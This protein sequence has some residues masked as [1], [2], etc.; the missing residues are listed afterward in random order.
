MNNKMK[1]TLDHI[2]PSCIS[3][4]MTVFHIFKNV[5]VNSVLNLKTREQAVGFPR[6]DIVLG[7][8]ENCGF[9][10]NVAF[11]SALLEYSAEY[12]STQS[13]SPTYSSFARRQAE[14]L[15]ERHDLRGKDLL[16]IGCGNGEFLAM[17][18]ELGDNRGLGF[19]PA[20]VEGRI[21]GSKN[22]NIEFIKDYYSE[23]YS[24]Y[25][26][27]FLYCKMTLEHIHN[28][29]EFIGMVRNSIGDHKNTFVFF[30]VPDVARILQDC[31]FEDIYYEHCSYF[32]PGSLARLFRSRDFDVLNLTNDYD[33]QYVMIDTKP[34]NGQP[35]KTLEEEADLE[36]FKMLVAEFPSKFQRK[37]S[38]W[39]ESLDRIKLDGKSAVIWGSGSK[40]VTFLITMGIR[41]EIQYVVDI[42]PHRQGTFMA[43]TGH[44]IVSP[45]FLKN[46]KPDV[47]I[48]MN[49]I[50][51]NEIRQDL[52]RMGLSPEILTL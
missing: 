30:Q 35:G 38:Q 1:N 26:T 21:S 6:G 32:S 5:P 49:A 28:T 43:G 44:E 9:I 50:Y 16:E 7:F 48:V 20:Y 37:I 23:K 33:G 47:V 46:F 40:G 29:G 3:I 36:K 4:G 22:L 10:S 11:D 52:T 2:C 17:L 41:E 31:A 12:E 39:R 18:C 14:Q 25:K 27:D 19:D 8:C 51:K 42:N 24:K 45:E 13:F 34:L 15:I